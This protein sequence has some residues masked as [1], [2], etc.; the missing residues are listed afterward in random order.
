MVLLS[1][2]IFFP[3]IKVIPNDSRTILSNSR[4]FHIEPGRFQLILTFFLILSDFR[5]SDWF[6]TIESAIFPLRPT[7]SWCSIL[8]T[9][10][11]EKKPQ[12]YCCLIY[13]FRYYHEKRLWKN[14][15]RSSLWL[16]LDTMCIV[17]EGYF[18]CIWCS[19]F[20]SIEPI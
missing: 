17:L 4:W 15:C 14:D 1:K 9:L 20:R 6:H 8:F 2:M 13:E 11:I 7:V 10:F 16:N 18:R 5:D 3:L 12:L 19:F